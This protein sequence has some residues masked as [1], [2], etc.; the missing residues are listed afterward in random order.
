[1]ELN[2]NKNAGKVAIG[3]I[4]VLSVVV[5]GS[6]LYVGFVAVNTDIAIMDNGGDD[7]FD[8][9]L[10]RDHTYLLAD[11]HIES[12]RR[13]DIEFVPCEFSESVAS[14]MFRHKVIDVTRILDG[15]LYPE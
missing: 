9:T 13:G 1:M 10:F 2:T 6:M 8:N 7:G 11:Y 3:L 15:L 4:F 12:I 14:N 5:F